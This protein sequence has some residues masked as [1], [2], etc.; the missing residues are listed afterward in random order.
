MRSQ[1]FFADHKIR[2]AY[3]KLENSNNEKKKLY[4]WINRAIDDLAENC[5][6]G[7]QISKK[8]IPRDYSRKYGARNLWKYNL[9][10][11]WRVLYTIKKEEAEIISVILEWLPHTEHERKFKY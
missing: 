4:E 5:F 10:N 9:P 3:R 8:Q 6:C 1:V 7:I 2:E 11:A